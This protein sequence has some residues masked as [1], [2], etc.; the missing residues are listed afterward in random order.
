MQ[1]VGTERIALGLL[2]LGLG[3]VWG[4]EQGGSS[5]SNLL[6][7]GSAPPTIM[8]EGWVDGPPLAWEQLAGKVAVVDIWAYWCGPCRAAAPGLVQTYDRYRAQGVVFLGLT[9]EGRNKLDEIRGFIRD[10]GIRWPTAYGADATISS[11]G[12]RFLP[13]VIVIGR[14]GRVF[15]N[16]ELGGTLDEA[17]RG[18]LAQGRSA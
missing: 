14:D 3:L 5:G 7:P 13:T 15:W 9:S 2:L 8:A 18:A 6:A 10:A 4:C 16:S 1:R 11:F 12:V 17:I